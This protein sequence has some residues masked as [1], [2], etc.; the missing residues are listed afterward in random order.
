MVRVLRGYPLR[1][2]QHSC[3]F[4]YYGLF[5]KFAVHNNQL[6]IR[7]GERLQDPFGMLDFGFVRG[8]Y[9]VENG[10]LLRM[11]GAL[12]AKSK[13]CCQLGLAPH[14]LEVVQSEVRHIDRVYSRTG[15]C[16]DDARAGLQEG[17]PTKLGGHVEATE[18]QGVDPRTASSDRVSGL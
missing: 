15:R 9:I 8:K 18:E 16:V 1:D 3:H 2:C 10:N 5:D 17:F 11:D 7:L 13:V 14:S 4:P 6:C 12:S